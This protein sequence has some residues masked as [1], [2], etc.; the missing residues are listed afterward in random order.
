MAEI[1]IVLQRLVCLLEDQQVDFDILTHEPVFTSEQAANVRG[2]SMSSGANA[3]ICKVDQKF[4]MFVMPADR[5]LS[6]KQV[7]KQLKARSLRFANLDEVLEWTELE[8]GAIPPFGS[9]FGL[10]TYCDQALA[11]EPTI[12][13]NAGNHARSISMSYTD[14]LKVERPTLGSFAK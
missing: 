12:N 14:F 9:L 7:R 1:Q 10:P 13:F 8:P 2:A 11:N 4:L 5:R 3:L 6:G